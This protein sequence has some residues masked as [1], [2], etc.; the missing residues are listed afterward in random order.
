MFTGIVEELGT[1]KSIEKGAHC[2]VLT[3]GAAYILDDLKSGDSVA[4]DGVCLTVK[5]LTGNG[6]SADVMHE[7]V[8]RTKLWTLRPGSPVNL[9]RAMPA[10]GRFGGHIVAGH[11]DGT[12]TIRSVKKDENAV[13]FAIGASPAVLRYIVEKGSVAVDGVSLTVTQVTE[14]T[15]EVSVI[16]HTAENTVLGSARAGDTVNV[17]C[18]CIGKYVEK[19]LCKTGGITEEFLEKYDF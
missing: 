2:A 13:R 14:R 11:I 9:E 4:V 17:E 19:L 6:F 1:V 16:P 8:E 12:G 5:R 7:T 15:F 3:I 18:D 10:N